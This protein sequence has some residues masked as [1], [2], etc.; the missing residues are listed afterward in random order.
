[1]FRCDWLKTSKLC[2]VFGRLYVGTVL[3]YQRR[4]HHAPTASPSLSKVEAPARTTIYHDLQRCSSL[5]DD[6]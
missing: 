3:A 6:R 1:M 5:H 4:F 2:W